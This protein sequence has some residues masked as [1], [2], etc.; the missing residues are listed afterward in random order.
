MRLA[1]DTRLERPGGPGCS[2]PALRLRVCPSVS[3]LAVLGAGCH[4]DEN[5]SDVRIVKE[6]VSGVA[7]TAEWCFGAA[8]GRE[9]A[10][11]LIICNKISS[12]AG[13]WR[14]YGWV[15]IGCSQTIALD[16]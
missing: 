12:I 15:S 7:E 9:A 11:R 1:I 8:R 13:R 5:A 6:R 10:I 3:I 2:A 16:R 14:S 4:W